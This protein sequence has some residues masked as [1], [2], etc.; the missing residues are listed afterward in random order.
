MS[1]RSAGFPAGLLVTLVMF[2]CTM[3]L[4]AAGGE[5]PDA[6]KGS[7]AMGSARQSA[8]T[9]APGQANEYVGEETCLACHETRAYTATRHGL[10][11][12]PRSPAATHGCESCHGPGKA[13]AEEATRR[14]S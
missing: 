4:T 13:H 11:S 6:R 3:V 8:P 2:V 7:K 12:I 14:R 1:K 5:N 10:K 9:T